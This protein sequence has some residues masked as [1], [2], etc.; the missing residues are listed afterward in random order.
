[1][2][3]AITWSYNHGIKQYEKR[4]NEKRQQRKERE[5]GIENIIILLGQVV[6]A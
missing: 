4:E 5:K 6:E 2:P 1:M 3:T